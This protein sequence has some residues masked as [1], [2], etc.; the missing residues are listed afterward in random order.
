MFKFNP[1]P[2]SVTAKVPDAE[3]QC[4]GAATAIALT[5]SRGSLHCVN[6]LMMVASLCN[7][8]VDTI[9]LVL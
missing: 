7:L 3:W 2:V 6:V 4:N 8:Q 9:L 5:D 1:N